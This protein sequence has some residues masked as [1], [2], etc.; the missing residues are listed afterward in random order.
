MSKQELKNSQLKTMLNKVGKTPIDEPEIFSLL[1]DEPKRAIFKVPQFVIERA[2]KDI[3][4]FESKDLALFYRLVRDKVTDVRYE[5]GKFKSTEKTKDLQNI[6]FEEENEL[7]VLSQEL[8]ELG[9]DDEDE[10]EDQVKKQQDYIWGIV[11]ISK[12][13]LTDWEINLVE[14]IVMSQMSDMAKTALTPLDDE[15]GN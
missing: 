11:N 5:N 2:K 9:T 10:F 13:G 7:F 1:T 8:N 12:K 4:S 15:L 3:A 14:A 6:S